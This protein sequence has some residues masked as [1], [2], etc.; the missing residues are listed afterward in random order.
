MHVS[1]SG[2]QEVA[3]EDM[4]LPGVEDMRWMAEEVAVEQLVY[5]SVHLG[6]DSP[7]HTYIANRHGHIVS[8]LPI[9]LH[10]KGHLPLR[11]P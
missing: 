7:S 9:G 11:F 10:S 3:A 6:P 2:T 4:N 1:I 5:R 8:G